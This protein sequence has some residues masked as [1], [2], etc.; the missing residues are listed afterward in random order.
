MSSD[1]YQHAA[2]KLSLMSFDQHV[3]AVLA[4]SVLSLVLTTSGLS[5]DRKQ[6]EPDRVREAL[7]RGEIM[8]LTQILNIASRNVPGNVIKIELEYDD[9]DTLIYAIKVLDNDGQV[10][11]L[12][13]DA[14]SGVVL[15][16]RA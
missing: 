10:H 14:R 8:S 3:R 2:G 6:S 16:P 4:T 12:N 5:D 13:I 11:K 1:S 15:H 9:G 7:R